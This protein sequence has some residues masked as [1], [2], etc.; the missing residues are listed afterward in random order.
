[1][2]LPWAHRAGFCLQWESTMKALV[3]TGKTELYELGPGAQIKSMLK[4]ID[5]GVWKSTKTVAA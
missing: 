4:R 3:A 1:M 5:N 2:G